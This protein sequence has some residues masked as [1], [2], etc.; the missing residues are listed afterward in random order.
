MPVS[1]RPSDLFRV[2][3]A[4]LTLSAMHADA[5]AF[6]YHSGGERDLFDSCGSNTRTLMCVFVAGVIYMLG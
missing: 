5:T 6:Y 4:R 1:V 2:F 3:A